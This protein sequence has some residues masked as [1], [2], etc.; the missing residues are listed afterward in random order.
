MLKGLVKGSKTSVEHI[1]LG[2]LHKRCSVALQN[3]AQQVRLSILCLDPAA[4]ILIQA[5]HEAS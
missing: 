5:L 2:L 4:L 3:G 1:C